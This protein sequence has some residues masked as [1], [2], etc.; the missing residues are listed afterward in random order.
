MPL[1]LGDLTE[2]AGDGSRRSATEPCAE[3]GRALNEAIVSQCTRS[4]SPVVAR[5]AVSSVV[6][7]IWRGGKL[8]PEP[9][10]LWCKVHD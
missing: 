10:L 3:S 9:Q 7:V 8:L 6:G 5:S 2:I 4:G 1:Y